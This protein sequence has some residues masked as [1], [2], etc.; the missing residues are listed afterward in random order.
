MTYHKYLLLVCQT[1]HVFV[2]TWVKICVYV[3][4]CMC[5]LMSNRQLTAIKTLSYIDP[6]AFK[7]LP[8][9]KYL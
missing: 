7:D 5:V 9:L 8:N 1:F 3:F 2:F 6:E 4:L